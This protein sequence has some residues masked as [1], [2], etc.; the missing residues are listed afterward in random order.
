MQGTENIE[1][2]ED[3]VDRAKWLRKQADEHNGLGI[4]LISIAKRLKAIENV[5]DLDKRRT[6]EETN[7]KT[8]QAYNKQA[9][10]QS[11]DRRTELATR[12]GRV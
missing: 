1:E 5:E 12:A 4:K 11:K 3:L 8:F 2:Q 9:S 6:N 7:A 10:R